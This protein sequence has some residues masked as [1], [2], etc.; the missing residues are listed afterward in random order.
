MHGYS[1]TRISCMATACAMNWSWS[2]Q[3]GREHSGWAPAVR[4][5][6]AALRTDPLLG[7]YVGGGLDLILDTTYCDAQYTFP[8]QV[9]S[10]SAIPA[11]HTLG[12]HRLEHE[13]RAVA[14][15]FLDA[16]F[17]AYR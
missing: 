9:H 16:T 10:H 4:R 5:L 3:R 12:L 17:R 13:R 2:D 8:S 1:L 11:P 6:T 15:R 7:R 14:V